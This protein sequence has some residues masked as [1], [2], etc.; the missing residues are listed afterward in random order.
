MAPE[1]L[2]ALAERLDPPGHGPGAGLRQRLAQARVRVAQGE[3]L[4]RVHQFQARAR[5]QA[6]HEALRRL[7][8]G[9]GR[10]RAP[11]EHAA[12]A[13]PERQVPAPAVLRGL[14]RLLGAV[15]VLGRGRLRFRVGHGA[16]SARG[17]VRRLRGQPGLDVA[18]G[19]PAAPGAEAA[20][21]L[22]LARRQG[23]A[24]AQLPAHEQRAADEAAGEQGDGDGDGDR[25]GRRAR[26]LG[27]LLGARGL[28]EPIQRPHHVHGRV[29]QDVGLGLARL[30]GGREGAVPERGGE[31]RPRVIPGRLE[32]HD[33]QAALEPP[34]VRVPRL[35]V[36]A[37]AV[38]GLAAGREEDARGSGGLVER[39]RVDAAQRHLQLRE[40]GRPRG[41][42]RRLGRRPRRLHVQGLAGGAA[43]LRRGH[44][45]VARAPAAPGRVVPGDVVAATGPVVAGVKPVRVVD[46]A[47]E[48]RAGVLGLGRGDR[49][50]GSRSLGWPWSRFAR[51]LGRGRS[52]RLPARPGRRDRGG[53]RSRSWRFSHGLRRGPD[54]LR[55]SG[56]RSGRRGR[57]RRL[58]RL[59][60]PR[61]GQ[62]RGLLRG[63]RR[64]AQ[65][66][67]GAIEAAN[68]RV[69]VFAEA[70]ARGMA[71]LQ[72]VR[73]CFSVLR[74]LLL[75]R[76][77]AGP[78]G[79]LL[80][81]P[82]RVAEP[83]V[84]ALLAALRVLVI[85]VEAN[86][87]VVA[88]R[89]VVGALLA[90]DRA[91]P[92]RGPRRRLLG[93]P[94]RR[95]EPAVRAGLAA[96]RHVSFFLEARPAAVAARKRVRALLSARG[97]LPLGRLGGRLHGLGS[98]PRRRVAL[99]AVGAVLAAKGR[100]VVFFVARPLG[101]A[102][103]AGVRALLAAAAAG[104][105]VLGPGAVGLAVPAAVP[106]GVGTALEGRARVLSAVEPT[107]E[108][109]DALRVVVVRAGRG[110]HEVARVA[111]AQ[112]P[113][114][115]ALAVPIAALVVLAVAFVQTIAE[116]IEVVAERRVLVLVLPGVVL[117]PAVR[118]VV[119]RAPVLVPATK[120]VVPPAAAVLVAGA[121][122]LAFANTLAPGVEL[123]PVVSG[124]VAL[125]RVRAVVLPVVRDVVRGAAILI[126]RAV[127]LVPL[128]TLVLFTRFLAAGLAEVPA[129]I[130]EQPVVVE[131]FRAV[132]LV[133]IRAGTVVLVVPAFRAIVVLVVLVGAS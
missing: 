3:A 20:P 132:V 51:R 26:A 13:P 7:G 37:L 10:R 72:V 128:A 75:R 65:P 59:G 87:L 58:R 54:G 127:V 63:P 122:A 69:A 133:V 114:G 119:L 124:V 41:A 23:H 111:L 101:V 53:L 74:A 21:S 66:P 90:A 91:L 79:G 24:A 110:R 120:I 25:R 29:S 130:V 121:L 109:P 107:A 18:L 61:R 68:G 81:G 55:G 38:E 116:V 42:R 64:L 44:A 2:E 31:G 39:A 40:A 131:R 125:V 56:S 99:P 126:T 92:L 12:L 60:R 118:H 102:A 96:N 94:R 78:G 49:G 106:P 47:V 5:R 33:G 89:K 67:V 62:R 45:G 80:R 36:A 93:R 30:E 112:V 28:V 84:G 71:A 108:L 129:E 104:Q 57:P 97:A 52:R 16:R 43:G 6:P 103:R 17:L 113:L 77:G 34:P 1:A 32:R 4:G 83:A 88:A 27:A 15:G 86:A 98:R 76:P 82:R 19:P 14:R 35:G 117:V 95:A 85:F 48:A 9:H 115:V 105:V 8:P 73:T 11:R 50:L 70:R 22:A 100:V 123:V 46:A